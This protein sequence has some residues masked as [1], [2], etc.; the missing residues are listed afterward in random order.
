MSRIKEPFAKERK[1]NMAV[2]K[3]RGRGRTLSSQASPEVSGKL[4]ASLYLCKLPCGKGL[5]EVSLP[6]R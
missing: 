2:L 5:S 1:K 4:R 3:G 6:K